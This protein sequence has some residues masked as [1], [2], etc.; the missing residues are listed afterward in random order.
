M[1]TA[2]RR[3]EIV[4]SSEASKHLGQ[5]LK[6]VKRTGRIVLS[7]NNRLEAVILPIEEYEGI[8]EDLEHLLAALEIEERKA[9]DRGKRVPWQALKAKYGL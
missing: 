7:R 8:V 4:S 2:Y 5:V 3:E 6:E 1:E 9:R